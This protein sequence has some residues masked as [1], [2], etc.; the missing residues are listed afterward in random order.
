MDLEKLSSLQRELSA[1]RLLADQSKNQGA[2]VEI[3]EACLN[4]P[5]Y[6]IEY[7][8]FE[9]GD[10]EK[11]LAN[12]NQQGRLPDLKTR[13]GICLQIVEAICVAHDVGLIHKDLKPSNLL[14]RMVKESPSIAVADF[15]IGYLMDRSRL[16]SQGI[17]N[18]GFTELLSSNPSQASATL[19]YSPPDVDRNATAF[20]VYSLG[21]ILFQLAIGDLT[22]PYG[23]TFA[24]A[25][26]SNSEIV[27]IHNNWKRKALVD[28]I[29]DMI[30][31]M[32]TEEPSKRPAAKSVLSKLSEL[33]QNVEKEAELKRRDHLRSQLCKWG[34]RSLL[35][36]SLLTAGVLVV[37]YVTELQQSRR[38]T[39]ANEEVVPG[40]TASKNRYRSQVPVPRAKSDAVDK[41]VPLDYSGFTILKTSSFFDLSQWRSIEGSSMDEEI[42][43][44]INS[45]VID[46][47]RKKEVTSDNRYLRIYYSTEGLD[48]YIR[49]TTHPSKLVSRADREYLG[50]TRQDT[51]A[52]EIVIDLGDE[53]TGQVVRVV[54][55]ST[56]WNG[57]QRK[58]SNKQWA[59]VRALDNLGETELGMLFPKSLKPKTAPR[60]L[61]YERGRDRV[62]APSELQSFSNPIDSDGWVWRP[63]DVRKDYIYEIEFDWPP[64]STKP[65]AIA[66]Q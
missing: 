12:E 27:S 51:A 7:E 47:V 34:I 43:P 38:E 58:Q 24:S 42:E 20:D 2:F 4:Y 28:Y 8:Y 31:S 63:R 64:V 61:S 52:R 16:A 5:P 36:I 1:F 23:N 49:C 65:R 37:T 33:W 30:S 50:G 26:E 13:L 17:S 48:V 44:A 45:R 32:T 19:M 53:P 14:V 55:Q 22:R 60:L 11:W 57:F 46:V 56:I 66:S 3:H 15:G 41:F 9:G 21:V 29:T 59:A 25:I 35:V 39:L 62:E 18:S 10:L 40:C 54:V 6:F